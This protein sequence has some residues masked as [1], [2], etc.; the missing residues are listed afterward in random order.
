MAT[1]RALQDWYAAHCD[2]EWEHGYGVEIST[3]D[4]PGWSVEINLKGTELAGRPFTRTERG[5]EQEETDWATCWVE[6]ETFQGRCGA[7][8]LDEV[9]NAFFTWAAHE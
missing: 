9:L 8:N 7:R 4:N 6:N 1:I 3:L 2:G 5:M